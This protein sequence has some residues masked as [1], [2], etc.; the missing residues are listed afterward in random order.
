M[1]ITT[2]VA[3]ALH[4]L[5]AGVWTGVVV[6]TTWKLL[7]LAA[8]SDLSPAVLEGAAGGLSTFSR[9]SAVVLPATGL[10][11]VWTQYG[12]LAGLTVPPRGHAVLTMVVLWLL[13]TGMTEAGAARIR[14]AAADGKVRTA[15]RESG[16]FLK[17]ASAAGVVTLLLGG[18]LAA[19]PL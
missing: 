17:A 18:Y 13:M 5:F 12:G 2:T 14:E 1:G 4:T 6:F 15:A 9:T 8:D 11:M 16:R 7:P 19:P 3:Y 10:W